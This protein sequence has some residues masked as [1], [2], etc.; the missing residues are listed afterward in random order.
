MYQLKNM[1]NKG[2]S[3]ISWEAW[4]WHDV[5][6]AIHSPL[7]AERKQPT[8][9]HSPPTSATV[10]CCFAPGLLMKRSV[11]GNLWQCVA[12]GEVREGW[13]SP[14]HL[15][16]D[17]CTPSLGHEQDIVSTWFPHIRPILFF[18]ARSSLIGYPTSFI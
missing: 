15:W 17:D 5:G 11:C 18:K 4:M 10:H 2:L 12:C 14:L 9:R 8:L 13:S 7:V 16:V 6:K 1:F 3:L